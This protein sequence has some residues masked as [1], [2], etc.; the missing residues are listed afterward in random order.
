M[1]PPGLVLIQQILAHFFAAGIVEHQQVKRVIRIAAGIQAVQAGF[2][3]IQHL[4]I[5]A[6]QKGDVV[7]HGHGHARRFG[8]FFNIFGRVLSDTHNDF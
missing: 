8:N 1:N 6:A 3:H 4:G 5:K 7:Q 2:K